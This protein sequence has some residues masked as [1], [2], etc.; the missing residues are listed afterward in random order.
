MDLFL[1]LMSRLYSHAGERVLDTEGVCRVSW[2]TGVPPKV[3][4]DQPS[5]A[6]MYDYYLGGAHNFAID[7]EAAERA[8]AAMPATVAGART[9]RAFLQRAVRFLVDEAGLR[10]FI[11]P[12]SV[13]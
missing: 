2:P 11:G 13:L 7:R 12:G 3:N 9:N 6:R 8:I 10:P 5:A 4:L 1:G